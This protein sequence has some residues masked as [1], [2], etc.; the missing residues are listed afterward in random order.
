[1]YLE[2]LFAELFPTGIANNLDDGKPLVLL[3]Y[4]YSCLQD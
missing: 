3:R 2:N 1:M 4:T